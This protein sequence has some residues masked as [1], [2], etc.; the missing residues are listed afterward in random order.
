MICSRCRAVNLDR[1]LM[2]VQCGNAFSETGT[3]E[4]FAGSHSAAPAMSAAASKPS[5]AAGV[6]TPVPESTLEGP[7]PPV[8]AFSSALEPG[9]NFGPRYG[10]E[11]LI[12][13]GGMGTVYK[14][15]DKELGRTVAIKLLR[16]ELVAHPD[17]LQRFKQELLLAS[18]IS[19][20]NILRIHD[21]GEVSGVKFISMAYIEGEDLHSL[22]AKRGRLPVARLVEIGR[23]LAAA[24]EA[25]HAEGVVHRDLKPQNIL[26]DSGGN[27]Y[28][29]DFGLAKSFEQSA[30]GM[31]RTGD[32]LGTPR[33]MSP[34]QVEAKTVDHRSDLYALG[35]IL[36]EMATGDVPFAGNSAFQVMYQ[37]VKQKPTD[38]K[39]VNPDLPDYL[40]RIILRCLERDPT[41][42]YQQAREILDDLDAERVPSLAHSVQFSLPLPA[43]RG[44]VV[45]GAVAL[46]LLAL[47]FAVPSFRHFILRPPAENTAVRVGVSSPGAGKYLAVLPFRVLGDPGP[48]GYVAEGMVEALSA[49]LFQL[50]DVRLASPAAVEKTS[51]KESLEKI[52]RELGVNLLVQGTLQGSGGKIRVTVNLE[53]AV[54]GRRLW[55]QEFSGVPQDLLTLE[56]QIYAKL[57]DALE[58]KPTTEEQA[59]TGHPTEDLAAYDS[60]LRGRQVMRNQ[61]DIK[62]V[63]SAIHYYGDAL[64][65]DPRFALAYA[66][67][68][69]AS[70]RMYHEKKDAVW[71]EKALAAAQQALQLNNNLPEVYLSLASAYVSTGRTVEAIIELKRAVQLAPN[72]DESWRRLGDAYRAAGNK[73]QAMAA[74]QKAIDLNPY[75]WF[76]YNALGSAYLKFGES[77]KAL[78]AFHRVTE[79]APDNAA[80]YRNLGVVYFTLGQWDQCIAAFEKSLTIEKHPIAYSNLGTAY[81]Y[82][83]RYDDAVKAFEQAAEMDPNSEFGMG[84]LADA[85]R[86]AGQTQKASATYGKAIELGY[87]AVSVNPRDADTMGRMAEYFAKKGYTARA[88]DLIHHARSIDQNDPSLIYSEVVVDCLANRLPEALTSLEEAFRKGYPPREAENDPELATLRAQPRFQQLMKEFS[89]AAKPVPRT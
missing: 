81:F 78:N 47:A 9:A 71:A 53:D 14:A 26:I 64:K 46:V 36:Y 51:K 35:L 6:L 86:W 52:A 75:Y 68:A 69:D 56:D 10:I 31:T 80:G 19:H 22:L 67:L 7:G 83:K 44:W 43:H 88:L 39:L 33:Y 34:E 25:A 74:Y 63:E 15:R 27:V 60:Y 85:Y 5:A 49:K 3:E 42:R 41:R 8:S 55:T 30:M 65:K 79:V 12:G 4:T 73:D 87:K 59:M 24:L 28:I 1:A 16:R 2:C 23:Q 58:L 76:N 82:L 29:S 62:S 89:G 40:S 32:I 45:G 20:K 38:P 66:G 84:N 77:Q 57:V 11:C 13:E 37:R 50:R 54:A 61:L 21:L 48:L 70:L 17:A 72:S 18:K